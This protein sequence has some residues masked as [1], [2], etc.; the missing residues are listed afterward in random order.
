[1]HRQVH[2]PTIVDQPYFCFPWS[3]GRYAD[4]PGHSVTREAGSLNNFSIHV[5]AAGHGYVEA[6]GK[7][8]ELRRGD[9]FLYFPMSAQRYYSG[10]DEPWDVLWVHFYGREPLMAHLLERRMH[11]SLVWTL[12]QLAD[13]EEAHE[14]LLDESERYKMLRPTRLSTLTYAVVAE[15]MAQ[16]EPLTPNSPAGA[17]AYERIVR[18]LPVMQSKAC[19]PFLLEEWAEAA[20]VSTYYFCKLFRRAANMTPL[21]FMTRCRLQTAKQRLLEHKEA[22]VGAIARDAGYPSV[23]YFNKRFLEYE[24]MTPT[25]Y[26]KLFER[27][28]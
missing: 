11:R 21:E 17:D 3:V 7:R 28:S 1:M 25:Q 12:R 5:V 20:G 26:R 24:G 2:F 22:A 15:F 9:A 23:S 14:L 19:E 4:W 27:G 16:A 18:L 10:E 8:Y 6:E 13:W